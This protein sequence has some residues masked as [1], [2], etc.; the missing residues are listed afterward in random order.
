MSL[1]PLLEI[2]TVIRWIHSCCNKNYNSQFHLY[3]TNIIVLVA[4]SRDTL[5]RKIGGFL[6]FL[7]PIYAAWKVVIMASIL[8]VIM[9]AILSGGPSEML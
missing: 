7:L 6:S 1:F 3:L 8:V 9:V 5:K 4:V 2:S